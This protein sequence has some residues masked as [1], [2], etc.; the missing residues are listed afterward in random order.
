MTIKTETIT[1]ITCDICGKEI[2]EFE[3]KNNSFRLIGKA[4]I[5]CT[6]HD[7]SKGGVIHEID[8][9]LCNKCTESWHKF[10]NGEYVNN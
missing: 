1:T 6:G 5:T 8:W 3:R 9:D 7:G 4:E 2:S 10:T